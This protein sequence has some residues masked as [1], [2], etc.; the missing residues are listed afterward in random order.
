MNHR[1][2]LHHELWNLAQGQE[3]VSTVQPCKNFTSIVISRSLSGPW[4]RLLVV[5][6]VRLP[7]PSS[8]RG[9]ARAP[10]PG[11]PPGT[12]NM[13]Y[14][15][16]RVINLPMQ[17]VDNL[18]LLLGPPQDAGFEAPRLQLP[19][20]HGPRPLDSSPFEPDPGSGTIAVQG[21]ITSWVG[22]SVGFFLGVGQG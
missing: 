21:G 15:H 3:P 12:E 7:R 9:L 16:D 20:A 2:N 10:G 11:Q 1:P 18:S 17:E 22:R 19:V 5:L 4:I 6:L 13:H 14:N 8:S